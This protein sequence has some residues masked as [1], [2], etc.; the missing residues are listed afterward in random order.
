MQF[1]GHSL[2]MRNGIST[3]DFPVRHGHMHTVPYCIWSAMMWK[4]TFCVLSLAKNLHMLSF[5]YIHWIT[6]QTCCFCIIV[7]LKHPVTCPLNERFAWVNVTLPHSNICYLCETWSPIPMWTNRNDIRSHCKT[8]LLMF[9]GHM[10]GTGEENV[11]A[12]VTGAHSLC[13]FRSVAFIRC[14]GVG[15]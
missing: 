11:S 4:N 7:Y 10:Y 6:F 1:L 15:Q 9:S 13:I 2:G 5:V 8:H 14:K 12:T 3:R